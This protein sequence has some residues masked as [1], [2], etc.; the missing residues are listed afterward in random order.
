[1]AFD[2]DAVEREFRTG[3][4]SVSKISR[5]FGVSHTA[6]NK[7]A[8]REGWTRNLF[9]K[10]QS[11]GLAPKVSAEVAIPVSAAL[12]PETTKKEYPNLKRIPPGQ[13]G[14]PA[15]RPVGSRNKLGEAFIEALHNDFTVHGPKVIETVRVDKPD[16]YLKVIATI[17]PKQVEIKEGAFDGIGDEE[18]AA[19]LVAA[20]SAL[21]VNGGDG[22]G[23]SAE[24]FAQPTET[25]SKLH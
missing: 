23:T 3:Q 22:A 4:D 18:L 17:L 7:R 25:L 2:W 1:M 15:G 10:E 8:K 19:L 24:N 20:R 13:S 16:Q 6:I 14:N 12:K 21:G 9:P 5:K 11:E